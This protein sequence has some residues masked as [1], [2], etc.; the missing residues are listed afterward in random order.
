[1]GNKLY[2]DSRVTNLSDI[3][4]FPSENLKDE[5]KLPNDSSN[6][7]NL[8]VWKFYE[9]SEDKVK[10]SP[11]DITKIAE[12]HFLFS[13]YEAYI[14][15]LVGYGS[16]QSKDQDIFPSSLWG[17]VESSSNMTPRGLKYVFSSSE[18]KETCDN[19]ESF[20][21]SNRAF[22]NSSFNYVI[23]IWNGK[24]T[25]PMVK[26]TVMM[27]AFDLDKKLTKTNLLSRLYFGDYIESSGKSFKNGS[28]VSINNNINTVESPAKKPS[29]QVGPNSAEFRDFHETVY[30]LQ[31]LYPNGNNNEKQV[32]QKKT[33][34][35]K[36]IENFLKTVQTDYYS[37]FTPIDSMG[38]KIKMENEDTDD[39]DDNDIDLDDIGL[40]SNSP[41]KK[42]CS[43]A[44][45]NFKISAI[46][47]LILEIKQNI[48]NDGI[49]THI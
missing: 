5:C 27:N 33:L 3:L 16:D 30:L 22:K 45:N 42:A 47:N 40:V 26:S 25:H 12:D 41:Q 39:I 20:M 32:L 14:I 18:E 37:N 34:Y 19:L 49:F 21:V 43:N 8:K 29:N 24:N 6:Y 35:P 4:N 44:Q 13:S 15:L 17:I 38:N 48:V 1:M 2:V 9:D 36:F 46:P 23:F 10:N 7:Q 11:L 28:V 31:C